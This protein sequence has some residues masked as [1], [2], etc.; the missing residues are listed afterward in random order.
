M[1]RV[2][3]EA[4]Q[5]LI[6]GEMDPVQRLA[7]TVQG[8]PGTQLRRERLLHRGCK[9]LADAEGQGAKCALLV[10]FK[11]GVDGNDPVEVNGG[12]G[13]VLGRLHL[14]MGNLPPRVRRPKLA[15]DHYPLADGE[16]RFEP[17]TGLEK[18]GGHAAR[19]IADDGAKLAPAADRDVSG[20]LD[21]SDDHPSLAG[22]QLRDLAHSTAV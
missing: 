11:A 16:P 14:R 10:S 13:Q 6:A 1:A 12:G 9:A 4:D 2:R 5:I 15:G 22:P 21:R 8:K 7:Q 18:R 17:G 3:V 19:F 20:R